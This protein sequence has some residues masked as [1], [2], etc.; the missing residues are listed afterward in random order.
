M[1]LAII[2]A[3][4]SDANLI[5]N[6]WWDIYISKLIMSD[7]VSRSRRYLLIILLVTSL[8]CAS[9]RFIQYN[10]LPDA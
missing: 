1:C 9:H 3:N 6:S 7:T 8:G 4:A 5:T 2:V 10:I